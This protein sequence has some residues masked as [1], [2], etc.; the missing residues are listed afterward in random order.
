MSLPA[1]AG[2]AAATTTPVNTKDLL[3]QIMKLTPTEQQQVLAH[4]KK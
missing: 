2:A 3:A 4:L 1:P